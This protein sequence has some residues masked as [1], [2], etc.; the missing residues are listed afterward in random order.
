[1]PQ[2]DRESAGLEHSAT[3]SGESDNA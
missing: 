1:V 3:A 2:R